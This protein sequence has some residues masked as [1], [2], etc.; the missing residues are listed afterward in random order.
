MTTLCK[1]TLKVGDVLNDKWVILDFIAKGGMGEVYRAHQTNLNRDV[2]IKV[3][4]REWLESIDED[5]EE[6]ETL[7]QRFRREVQAMAQIRHPNVLQVFDY[8]SITVEKCGQDA[9][10]DYIAMEYIPGGS[11][12]STMSEEGFYP[13]EAAVEG[14]INRYFMP[15]L[16]GVK[17]LHDNGIVHRDLK[18]ENIFIDQDTPKIADFGLARSSRLKPVTVSMDVKGSP[19]Y[20][21]PEH[22]FDFKRADQRADIYSL[23]KILF[24]VVDGKIKTGTMP[25][26]EARLAKTETPLFQELGQIIQM[27]TTENRDGRTASIQDLMGQLERVTHVLERRKKAENSPRSSA[28]SLLSQ[29]KWLWTGAAFAV[30]S[31]FAMA[32]WHFMG[33]P[34]LSSLKDL[35][36][37]PHQHKLQA[38][39][40]GAATGTTYAGNEAYTV[41]YPG[42][43]HLIQGGEFT[44][45]AVL[46]ENEK[47]SVQVTSFYM[48]EFFVTNQQFVDF[49]NQNL[50]HISIES[51]AVK[52]G[53]ANWLLLGEVH[54]GYEPI[55]YQKNEFHVKNPD[56]ASKPALR[57]TGY[58]ASAFANYFGRRLPTE[59]EMLYAMVKGSGN[60]KGIAAPPEDLGGE[61]TEHMTQMMG[62]KGKSA[63]SKA[64]RFPFSSFT[65]PSNLLNINGLN[66]GIGEW[67]YREQ[68]SF[69]GDPSKTNRYAVI[70]GVEGAPADTISLPTIVDRFPWEGFEEIGFRTVKS[71][72]SHSTEGSERQ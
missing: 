70:G 58:G 32:G 29:V 36:S 38:K 21:S 6:A 13:D 37:T 64:S 20:M 25:F 4:S 30:L 26:K 57:V 42:R 27:A 18:P 40:G 39:P 5:D 69:S 45:P 2:A 63:I 66:H 49:L 46:A 59:I 47:R 1:T 50:S 41:A 55:V 14:W 72:A 11:L 65:F 8:D 35:I 53:G 68:V 10:I 51:G 15:V 71:D 7:V 9:S 56:H 62:D 22:F 60:S 67:V 19:H 61:T 28:A 34:G 48:D 44:L 31:V 52:G 54:S 43:Q 33:E 23:G 3:V 17:A 16:A 24:E 12:R